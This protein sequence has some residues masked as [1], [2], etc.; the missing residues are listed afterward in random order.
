[1]KKLFSI[2]SNMQIHYHL[3][4]DFQKVANIQK[5]SG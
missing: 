5:A 3:K 1:M 2:T 4:Q